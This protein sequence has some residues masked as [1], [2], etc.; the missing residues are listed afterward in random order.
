MNENNE[1]LDIQPAYVIDSNN[2]NVLPLANM[3]FSRI[4]NQ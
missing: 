1:V 2:S 3:S 4:Y